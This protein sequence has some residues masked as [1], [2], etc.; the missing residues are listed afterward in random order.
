MKNLFVIFIITLGL[1]QCTPEQAIDYQLL[2]NM[3]IPVSASENRPVSFTNKKAAYYYTQSHVNDHPEWAW[4]EGLN[5][6]KKKIFHG[7]ELFVSGDQLD[8]RDTEVWV[9]PYK[10]TRIHHQQVTEELFMFDNKNI[11]EIA[12]ENSDKD[13]GIHL[14]GEKVEHITTTDNIVFF[15][16]MEG[17]RIIGVSSKANTPVLFDSGVVM[18]AGKGMGFFIAAGNDQADAAHLI[19][20]VRKNNVRWK[21]ERKQRMNRLLLENTYLKSDNDSL[22]LALNWMVSTMDQLITRQQGHG[23]YAGL[24][25]FNEYWG[26][27]EFIAL[28]GA[29]LVTG[30]FEWARKILLSFA[31]YQETDPASKFFGRVPNIVNPEN[32]DYHTTDGTPRFVIQLRE[33]VKYSGDTTIIKELYDNVKYSI[34]GSLKNWTDENYY[35]VHA[36]NETWMDARRAHDLMPYSPRGNRANDIQALW[37]NQLLAGVYFAEYTGDNTN[38]EKWQQIADQVKENFA[39]DFV[40]EDHEYLADRIDETDEKDFKLRPNQLFALD[41]IDDQTLKW[42]TT[43]ICW[44]ELVYPWGVASLNR[45]DDFFHPYHDSWENYHKDQAYHNG[46][47]WIWN[48]GIAMQRMIEAEQRETAYKLFDNM[49][50]KA[51]NRGVVGGLCENMDAYPRPGKTRAK[52]TGTYLQAWSNSEHLRIWYQYFLGIRPDMINN[53]LT[54]A[55]R[56]PDAINRLEYGFLVG[57]GNVMAGFKRGRFTTY[58]YKFNDIN[59]TLKIDIMPFEILTLN[60]TDGEEIAIVQKE[61]ELMV[62]TRDGNFSVGIDPGR[63]AEKSAADEYF[64][65]VEFC[66]P[67]D[68]KNHPVMEQTYQRK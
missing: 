27:D 9:Y 66:R 3:K 39:R 64:R 46:T 7:Y 32:I 13:I 1:I 38:A 30:Q 34:E 62:K 33:Y 42:Q 41:M 60:V 40:D 54:L 56:I 12:L 57:D 4:F 63:L 49:N 44:E 16:A 5:I 28:P 29:C 10:M 52:I 25:W 26:R 22:Q 24:P 31:E 47:I 21:N 20:E 15:K 53:L 11:L 8:N 65:D 67:M 61:K 43:R 59:T 14:K 58:T 2:D 50:E 36:D 37:Y 18:T 19:R 6:A 55:P 45:Q 68:I 17:N 48:N 51:L 35:L 23:I